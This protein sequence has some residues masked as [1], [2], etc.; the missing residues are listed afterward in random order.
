MDEKNLTLPNEIDLTKM[1]S[2]SAE[3]GVKVKKVTIKLRYE[4]INIGT[5]DSISGYTNS[6]SRANV[7]GISIG[8]DF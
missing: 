6:A 4:R 5:S 2:H 3:L 8:Y 7:T 1:L